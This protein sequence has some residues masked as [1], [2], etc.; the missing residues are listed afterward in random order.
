MDRWWTDDAQTLHRV[1]TVCR[2]VMT[3]WMLTVDGLEQLLDRWRS[4]GAPIAESLRPGLS[5][6][7]QDAIV[8]PLG[9]R[10]PHEARVWWGWHDGTN[11]TTASYAIGLDL[12]YLPLEKA[13]GVYK[14]QLHVAATVASGDDSLSP[15]DVWPDNWLPISIRGNGAMMVCDCSVPEGSPTPIRHVDHEFFNQAVDPVAPSLG[16][17]VS[18]WI[19]ALDTGAWTFNPGLKRWDH[20]PSRLSDPSVAGSHLV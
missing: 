9:L 10:L 17:V 20:D 7:A 16:T 11:T 12:L 15:E 3:E 6:Q 14:R 4:A 18:S 2:A 13:L 1:G 5:E 19:D 8:T